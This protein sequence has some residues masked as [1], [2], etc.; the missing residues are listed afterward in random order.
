MSYMIPTND[1]YVDTV[2]IAIAKAR[3]LHDATALM[4]AAG[5]KGWMNDQVKESIAR[6]VDRTF[7][8]LW[9]GTAEIDAL[10]RNAYRDEARAV[11][12]A[13]N[14]KFLTEPE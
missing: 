5:P 3:V 7:Q 12:S 1:S 6:T 11:I 4:E 10:N 8:N 13:L 2:A 9:N 14:L